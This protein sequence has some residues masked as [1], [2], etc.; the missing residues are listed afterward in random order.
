MKNN[1]TI[2][3][4]VT[5]INREPDAYF[6]AEIIAGLIADSGLVTDECYVLV[7]NSLIK[8]FTEDERDLRGDGMEDQADMCCELASVMR[9]ALSVLKCEEK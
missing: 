8:V 6:K 1:T 4:A 5:A 3:D 2:K 9:Q 7:I